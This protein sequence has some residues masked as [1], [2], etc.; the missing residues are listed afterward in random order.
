MEEALLDLL[1]GAPVYH[2]GLYR[3][4]LSSV[5]L[6]VLLPLYHPSQSFPNSSPTSSRPPGPLAI[7]CFPTRP[8]RSAR[9]PLTIR[10]PI[11]L[12]AIEYYS[13]LPQTINVDR[14]FILDPMV[15]TGNTALAAMQMMKEWGLGMEK[16]CFLGII[17]SRKALEGLEGKY[18]DVHV[19]T[20]E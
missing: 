9:Q 7:A 16:V 11:S 13:R 2:L 18:P 14:I 17:G 5:Y 8:T 3:Y 12:Q 20:A 19:S 6:Q 4:V 10:D 15:A 1:P